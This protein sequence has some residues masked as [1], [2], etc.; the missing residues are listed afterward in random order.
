MVNSRRLI[1]K[2][3]CINKALI[4]CSVQE[5]WLLQSKQ[6]RKTCVKSSW[7]RYLIWTLVCFNSIKEALRLLTSSYISLPDGP[8]R[9]VPALHLKLYDVYTEWNIQTQDCMN[10]VAAYSIKWI[11]PR[12]L[13]HHFIR[14]PPKFR[15]T[16]FVSLETLVSPVEFKIKLSAQNNIWLHGMS[17]CC[18]RNV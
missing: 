17:Y 1:E 3:H 10:F 2:W 7:R 8:C 11:Y 5:G 15:L 9:L 18:F 4:S 16:Y 12:C 14:I 6:E 13:M